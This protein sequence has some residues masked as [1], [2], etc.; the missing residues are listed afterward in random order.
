MMAKIAEGIFPRV[1]IIII[2]VNV[3]MILL[4]FAEC[5]LSLII[6]LLIFWEVFV[7]NIGG[8]FILDFAN[9]FLGGSSA[10]MLDVD[11]KC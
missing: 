7:K 1:N 3:K 6:L 5:S 8:F 11:L 9:P 10:L 4:S 2:N